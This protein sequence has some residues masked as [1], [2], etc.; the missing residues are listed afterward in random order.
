MN[1]QMKELKNDFPFNVL[2]F[3]GQIVFHGGKT[4]LSGAAMFEKDSINV[5]DIAK[6]KVKKPNKLK[7]FAYS[8]KSN[9]AV[10]T[11]K[12][13]FDLNNLILGCTGAGKTVL[14]ERLLLEQLNNGDS[15]VFIDPKESLETKERVKEMAKIFNKPFYDVS[16]GSKQSLSLFDGASKG[17]A[18]SSIIKALSWSEQYYKSISKLELSKVIK[19]LRSGTIDLREVWNNLDALNNEKI[20]GMISQLHD[21]V[22]QEFYNLVDGSEK[23]SLNKLRESNGVLYVGLS[24]LDYKEETRTLGRLIVYEMISH[25]GQCERNGNKK[26]K[27][28]IQF[29]IDEF[30]SVGT[31][32]ILD[33]MNKGRSSGVLTTLCIQ[34][35]SDLVRVDE[36]SKVLQ[37][38]L[39]DNVNNFFV[40]HTNDPDSVTYISSIIGT[41]ATTKITEQ[42]D[43]DNKTGVGSLRE[44]NQY[45]IHP[46]VFKN[47]NPGQFV[48]SS[49]M[50]SRYWDVVQ[51]YKRDY[52]DEIN[53]RS[54]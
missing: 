25:A 53:R 7:E 15:V 3:L 9:K 23:I 18:L 45:L 5:E 8:Y 2:W 11:S 30:A 33:L 43:Q 21:I 34:S 48:I 13:N 50:P 31:P 54:R 38:Q 4:L 44:V 32:D 47:L 20:S 17:V 6:G 36:G 39:V 52:I 16:I 35:V 12:I 49:K 1:N 27:N 51:V 29:F 28:N 40:G 19:S 26:F 22:N 41:K 24:S 10:D 46:E 14:S 42:I 37:G